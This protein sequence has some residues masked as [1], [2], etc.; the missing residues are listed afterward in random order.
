[1]GYIFMLLFGDGVITSISIILN[2]I[3]LKILNPNHSRDM[4]YGHLDCWVNILIESQD[5]FLLKSI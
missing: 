1:M 2:L 5:C 3:E 4:F